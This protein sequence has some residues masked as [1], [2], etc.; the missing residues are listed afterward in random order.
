MKLPVINA[1]N[2]ASLKASFTHPSNLECDGDL[3]HGS[4]APDGPSEVVDV[5]IPSPRRAVNR[6]RLRGRCKR[7]K[8]LTVFTT[9]TKNS[10]NTAQNHKSDIFLDP[11]IRS[12]N[13]SSASMTIFSASQT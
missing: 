3:L 11:M 10:D 13:L 7:R 4:E 8:E 1:P 6:N 5:A 9:R 12:V 2:L